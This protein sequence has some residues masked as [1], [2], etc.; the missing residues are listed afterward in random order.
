[1]ARWTIRSIILN[2]IQI[3]LRHLKRIPI[4]WRCIN[5]VYQINCENDSEVA[6]THTLQPPYQTY[7]KKNVHHR[8]AFYALNP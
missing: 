3:L 1:M 6:A 7:I 8:I 2:L 4:V 5:K